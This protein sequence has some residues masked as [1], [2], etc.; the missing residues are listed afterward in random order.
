MLKDLIM[1]GIIIGMLL[2]AGCASQKAVVCSAASDCA[3]LSPGQ[4]A[5]NW[6]CNAGK[7]GFVCSQLTGNNETD[8]IGKQLDQ[9]G[10]D[11]NELDLAYIDGL[12]KE[13]SALTW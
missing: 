1:I 7:C 13:L 3:S 11:Q 6:E 5:G 8:E 12:E 9:V 10:L 4:C 2:W